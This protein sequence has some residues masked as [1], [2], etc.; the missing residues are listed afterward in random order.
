MKKLIVFICLFFAVLALNARA[1][2]DDYRDADEKARISY[3]F[4]MAIGSNFN[5]STMG[6]EFDYHAFADGL[7]AVVENKPTLFSELEAMEI[8]ETALQ[9]SMEKRAVHNRSLE[10]EFLA[11]NRQ[12]LGVRVTASG[13]QYEII[14]N[15]DGEKPQADSIVR[16]NYVGT[17]IDGSPFDSSTEEGGAYIP[18][19]LVIP[20]WTEGLMLMG[21]GS[22][23]RLFIPS[24]LAYGIDGIQGIIPP[25][26][27]LIFTVELIE[28]I[29]Q[30]EAEY[31]EL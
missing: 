13:L 15:T 9:V 18:L 16:V 23:Y 20:G 27:T 7:K 1:I 29:K 12:R 5:L 26:A 24:A 19:E 11:T 2:H 4:G 21:E 25:Y 10:D 3:A 17:F 8:I 14:R 30:D 22:Q 6:I 31:E 28:I